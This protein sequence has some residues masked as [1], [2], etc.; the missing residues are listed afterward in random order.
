MQLSARI[1]TALAVLTVAVG[2]MVTVQ[3]KTPEVSASPG[4]IAV[5]NVGACVTSS[6]SKLDQT[7]CN[8]HHETFQF[9]QE[10][11]DD[12]IERSTIYATYAH[13]PKTAAE[14]PRAILQDSDLLKV[15]ITDT[16]RDTR[17]GVLI[18]AD[19]TTAATFLDAGVDG[20]TADADGPD[21][22]P[23]TEDDN[24][25]SRET[26]VRATLD[27][28]SGDFLPSVDTAVNF[29]RTDESPV[30]QTEGGPLTITFDTTDDPA[31]FDP[32]AP[33]TGTR[34][35]HMRFFGTLIDTPGGGTWTPPDDITPGD[36]IDLE[37]YV[38]V[39]EDVLSGNEISAATA[40]L[41]LDVPPEA[42]LTLE[43]IYYETSDIEY[44]MGGE[45]CR[46]AVVETPS[47]DDPA[48]GTQATCTSDELGD[49][50]DDRDSFV[51]EATSDGN[52]G[53]QNLYLR[54]TGR[55]TGIFEGFVRLTD[56]DGNGTDP[57][58]GVQP[59]TRVDD[60]GTEDTADDETLPIPAENWGLPIG[61]GSDDF[62]DGDA[63]TVSDDI[64]PDTATDEQ[65]TQ[66]MILG[67][68]AVK[69]ASAVLG[70]DSGPVTIR[71]KD[72]DGK[73]RTFDVQIDKEAPTIEVTAPTHD[74]ASDDD[75]PDFVGTFNDG[76]SGLAADS[77]SLYVDNDVD[78]TDSRPVWGRASDTEGAGPASATVNIITATTGSAPVVRASTD[79][80]MENGIQLR[81]EYAGFST[82]A[83]TR[84]AA[85]TFGIF[86][87]A[88]LYFDSDGDRGE[89][90][91]IPGEN[92]SNG[93]A[94]GRFDEGVRIN[95]TLDE[96]EEFNHAIDFQALVRDMAGNVG[97]SDSDPRKPTFIF[98]L[99]T[100]SGD[101]DTDAG[102]DVLGVFSRHVVYIDEV[103]PKLDENRTATGFYGRDSDKNL[104]SDRSAIMLVW[105]GNINEDDIGT[106]TFSIKLDEDTE[107]EV[108]EVKVDKHLVFLKLRDELPSDARPTVAIAAGQEVTDRAD[109]VTTSE[110]LD[111]VEAN[112]G[113]QPVFTVELS[114]G[115]GTGTGG[116]SESS[117]TKNTINVRITSDEDIT[118]APRIAV[119]CSN[120]QWTDLGEDGETGG[121]G[122]N[123]DKDKKLSDYVNDRSGS[124][125]SSPDPVE[126]ATCGAPKDPE[127]SDP[128]DIPNS[129]LVTETS[130]LSRPGNV[131]EYVWRNL[132][133]EANVPDGSV[134]AVV[135]GR[136]RA[137]YT[138]YE[139]DDSGTK[140]NW[141][142]ATAGFRFDEE[143]YSPV[144][145]DRGGSVEPMP[146]SEIDELRPFVR[147]NFSGEPTTV[148][149]TE[150]SI[151]GEDVLDELD[152]QG[153]NQFLYWP[154]ELAYGEHEVKLSAKD[155]A[156]NKEEGLSFKFT[157]TSRD[158][159]KIS[160]F[161]GWNAIS[162]PADPVDTTLEAV[163]S[164]D[165]IDR[166][167][168][169]DGSD[170]EQPWR[171]ATKD[172]GIWTT[173]TDY[174]PL[175]DVTAQYGY[176]VHSKGFTDL[177]VPLMGPLN[178]ETSP[179]PIPKHIPTN[180]GWNFVGVIDQDG[181]QTED[182]FG[183]TLK[184]SDDL[185][186]KAKD[187]M[188]GFVRA[189]TWDEIENSYAVLEEDDMIK[190][191][192]GIWVYFPDGDS[193]SP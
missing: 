80:G 23:S 140:N 75:D 111:P 129:L 124:L 158:D 163:F 93:D 137:N 85:S 156:D 32:V 15:S 131:W 135:W 92:F 133:D 54:E 139:L 65:K 149:V 185:E 105:D 25:P 76:E 106:E 150:F 183:E 138:T 174:A 153:N 27:L 4:S 102:E 24:N 67:G 86:P 55:F 68:P 91:S 29:E 12:A 47:V 41:L 43:L 166:V 160:L 107:V 3:T 21:N 109:N 165:D 180:P 179:H 122:V 83:Q 89:V 61:N 19:A 101:R 71:Y 164:I 9:E 90:K 16:D 189:Y 108:T 193:I 49:G 186:V 42:T 88:Q 34:G 87:A 182:S 192:E 181:D 17:T 144:N 132:E 58:S 84:S 145:N 96:D 169:W 173:S 176:W 26:V 125:T 14:E 70:V 48:K 64:S 170:T 188:P 136:D 191:G 184:N 59:L 148:T 104:I 143:F 120:L 78:K 159:F 45:E 117:L 36:F 113:I 119:V 35:D 162:F 77:F 74:S 46:P 130:S 95:F 6:L 146:G 20:G 175:T 44:I 2:M 123:A 167:F 151:D 18:S 161:A 126:G 60:K 10:G 73:T 31:D 190:I 172:A 154:S 118:G 7:D 128:D 171:I 147:L 69:E 97:F 116:E 57:V 37:D 8:D 56:A 1:L 168:G 114:G 51:A 38:R 100:K 62:P 141:N 79:N 5:I 177:Q 33:T 72:T 178:R 82:N 39:D 98:D 157:V 22:N 134:T 28:T 40:V 110:E 53:E 115:S 103:D 99:G 66:S 13:D 63:E 127:G 121:E 152:N 94:D 50:P 142:S 81:N 11:L 52:I 30:Q 187:Y 112:D 155:A